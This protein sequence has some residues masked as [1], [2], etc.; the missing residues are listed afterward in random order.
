MKIKNIRVTDRATLA[1]VDAEFGRYNVIY[2]QNAA[3][4]TL[5]SE[6]FRSAERAH[7]LDLGKA[8][9]ALDD[10][11]RVTD[12]EFK[13]GRLG[14][15]IRV[16]NSRFIDENVFLDNPSAIMLGSDFQANIQ[17]IHEL[18][19][20]VQQHD[21]EA[22]ELRTGVEIRRRNLNSDRATTAQWIKA[23]LAGLHSAKDGNS[24]WLSYD[25]TD[26]EKAMHKVSD[27]PRNH[28][29]S[30][31]RLAEIQKA[32]AAAPTSLNELRLVQPRMR[33]WMGRTDE[34]CRRAVRTESLPDADHDTPLLEWLRKGREFA[35]NSDGCPYCLQQIPPGRQKCLADRFS[36][37]D[38]NLRADT[39]SLRKEIDQWLEGASSIKLPSL[40]QLREDLRPAYAELLAL[41]RDNI[42]RCQQWCRTTK[43]AIKAKLEDPRRET[44]FCVPHPHWDAT[45]FDSI[46]EI[47]SENN[48]TSKLS[49]LGHEFE[50]GQIANRYDD[51]KSM[52]IKTASDEEV[53]NELDVENDAKR[54]ELAQLRR[55]SDGAL[56]G[57]D[58]LTEMLTAFVG[59]DEF[60]F[61]LNSDRLT[62]GV[63]R[64]HDLADGFSEG[65]RT[66]IGLMYFLISL[67][68]RDYDSDNG[69][70]VIDDPVTS[71]DDDRLFDAISRI[72][73]RTGARG[74][75][76]VTP[77]GQLFLLTHHIGLLDRLWREV[78]GN[79]K[80]TFFALTCSTDNGTRK[81]SLRR[82]DRPA[83]F[84]YHIA[85]DETARIAE[86]DRTIHNPWNSLR[87]CAEGF[88]MS[89][90]PIAFEN[91]HLEASVRMLAQSA[92][93]T[94]LNQEDI[95]TICNLIN[96]GSHMRGVHQPVDA[97]ADQEKAALTSRTLMNFMRTVAPTHYA[98]MENGR[99]NRSKQT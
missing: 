15:V 22:T 41:A 9:L 16:F 32:I 6:V 66:A 21:A 72:L 46:N 61:S 96:E 74:N 33:D 42:S 69:I 93:G 31:E 65:E 20:E 60:R 11:T 64:G 56:M 90:I 54:N 73:L 23:T 95:H 59:H 30:P 45:L 86:G 87:K 38:D 35:K 94:D 97:E 50:L 3:G 99:K 81:A 82:T 28:M 68:D 40:S 25:R 85:F 44:G 36:T 52:E 13:S 47:I 55:E 62:Y 37:D 19:D 63:Y 89:I 57:A 76:A 1:N 7:V 80:A 27:A 84:P 48:D 29:R 67:E 24:R 18:E 14:S 98:D 26:A 39:E 88:A 70:V 2:G 49:V 77:V 83:R 91:D 79:A 51:W 53:A 71:F 17:R 8:T 12:D 58:K 78:G 10:G 5:F 92:V 75:N 34:I 43:T 4:K